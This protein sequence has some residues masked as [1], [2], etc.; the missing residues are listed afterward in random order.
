MLKSIKERYRQIEAEERAKDRAAG[1]A[2]GVAVGRANLLQEL[3]MPPET[4]HPNEEN[5]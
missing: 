3:G 1:R 4:Q 2:K 5:S